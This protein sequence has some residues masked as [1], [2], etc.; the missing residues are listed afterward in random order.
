MNRFE[1]TYL[2]QKTLAPQLSPDKFEKERRLLRTEFEQ[3]REK[4][5]TLS[6]EISKDLPDFTVH[7]ISHIDAL[8]EMADLVT[9]ENF[10]LS[11]TEAFVLGSAFLIHDLGM[12]LAAYP[13]G[14]HE[15]KKGVTWMDGVTHCY[16]KMYGKNPTEEELASPESEIEKIVVSNILRLTH[17]KHA[18][19]LMLTSWKINKSEYFLIDNVD[20]RE[21]YGKIIGLIAHSHWWD[22]KE[23]PLRFPQ[24][25]GSPGFFPKEWTLDPLK[26]ACLL[27]ISD[28]IHLDERRAPG[29][30]WSIRKPA[31]Y[32]NMHWTFQNKLYQ[33][34]LEKGKLVYTSKSPF[35]IE[36]AEAWWLCFDTLNMV[37]TEL[38]EVDSL[39]ATYDRNRLSANG[40]AAIEDT[41]RFSK[42]IT[43]ENWIPLDTKIKV[44]DVN[45]LVERLGGEELYGKNYL[46]PIRELIQNSCDAIKARR[47][48]ENENES[49]GDV[50]VSFGQ[51]DDTFYFEIEDN[52]VGMSPKTLSTTLLDFG[53]SFWKSAEMNI[54]YPGLQSKGYNS[55]GRYG[56][57]FF[58]IFMLGKKVKVLSRKYEESWDNTWCLEFKQGTHSRAI[59]RKATG[60]EYCKNGGTRIKVWLE[61]PDIISK[62][63]RSFSLGMENWTM[64]EV[65]EHLCPSLEVNLF[66]VTEKNKKIKIITAND[67]LKLE[68][69]RFI[70]RILGKRNF[71]Q[72]QKY[73]KNIFSEL[74]KNIEYIKNDNDE[75]IGRGFLLGGFPF[76]SRTNYL[77]LRGIITIG[78]FNTTYINGILGLLKGVSLRAARDIAIP[79]ININIFKKWLL[80]QGKSVVTNSN[81]DIEIKLR[82]AEVMQTFECEIKTFPIAYYQSRFVSFIELVDILKSINNKLYTIHIMDIF[83]YSKRY[84]S[85]LILNENI[86][87]LEYGPMAMLSSSTGN[88]FYYKYPESE[89]LCFSKKLWWHKN[90]IN[91]LFELALAEAWGVSIDTILFNSHHIEELD[92][93][94]AIEIGEI[95]GRKVYEFGNVYLFPDNPVG[96]K[97]NKK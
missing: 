49:W 5:K 34:R 23:L 52:G 36:D 4:A 65:L 64:A 87:A 33:P 14:I 76:Y 17:A 40:I 21:S 54:E 24:I 81:I 79:D 70:K 37:D 83:S 73:E 7:D 47:I 74:I 1:Q 42:L 25:L 56:I 75:V 35:S 10:S 69:E 62:I 27:R 11:P 39:L 22:N 96:N 50:I 94:E 28:A 80:T 78:G 9:D 38:R 89:P 45:S 2:W 20:L 58:S 82:C 86:I 97:R 8:W 67:W 95:Q 16:Q 66:L 6:A 72:M 91:A 29:L 63:L 84:S 30:L 3:F 13:T 19:S 48:L 43:I 77:E 57:G 61:N 92:E 18:E 46:V 26:L 90:S 93:R 44:G 85:T 55:V 41:T 51:E 68:K 53:S 15:L 60:E 88:N 59:L 31:T 32:A 71:N 12:G